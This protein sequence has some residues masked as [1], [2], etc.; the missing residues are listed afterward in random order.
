MKQ[1]Q[2]RKQHRP[3]ARRFD[4]LPLDPRDPDIVRAQELDRRRAQPARRRAA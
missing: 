2:V 3:G 1:V 4:P